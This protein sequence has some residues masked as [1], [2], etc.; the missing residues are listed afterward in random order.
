MQDP[1]EWGRATGGF[2]YESERKWI[3]NFLFVWTIPRRP[4]R[5]LRFRWS[6]RQCAGLAELGDAGS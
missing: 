6:N 1:A 3:E 4:E 2:S 5:E